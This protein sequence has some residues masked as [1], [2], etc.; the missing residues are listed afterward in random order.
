MGYLVDDPSKPQDLG[1]AAKRYF[2]EG[3][4]KNFARETTPISCPMF[5][6]N[7]YYE[8][9]ITKFGNGEGKFRYIFISAYNTSIILTVLSLC[10]HSV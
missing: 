10:L 2:N 5:T 6:I 4:S 9:I 7:N 1:D 3:A 8:I